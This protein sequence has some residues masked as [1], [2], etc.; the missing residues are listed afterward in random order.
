MKLSVPKRHKGKKLYK[1]IWKDV[2]GYEGLYQISNLGRVKSLNYNKTGKEKILKAGKDKD[3]Y[4]IVGLSY[5]GELKSH[6]VHRLVAIAFVDGWFKD[7]QVDHIDTNKQNNIY[8]NLR[9]VTP[10]ENSN[11]ELTKEHYSESHKGKSLSEEHK[12][13]LSEVN[14]GKKPVYCVELDREFPSVIQCAREL[15]LNRSNIYEVCKGKLKSTG[16]YHFYYAEDILY[17]S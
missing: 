13:K 10:K 9:W 11:N 4:L 8:T 14:K 3:G 12:K 2:V 1:E 16:G 5:K 6:R 17:K 15:G 7:A